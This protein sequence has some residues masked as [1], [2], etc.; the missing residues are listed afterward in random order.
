[1]LQNLEGTFKDSKWEMRVWTL[2]ESKAPRISI[3]VAT[4]KSLLLK[5]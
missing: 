4:K 1:M 5:E 2:T 3:K